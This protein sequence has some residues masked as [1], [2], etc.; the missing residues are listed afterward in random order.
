MH[1][2]WVRYALL[3]AVVA[4]AGAWGLSQRP[5]HEERDVAQER[6][7]EATPPLSPAYSI[8][9]TFRC[10]HDGLKAVELLVALYNPEA[11]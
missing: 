7:E 2:G 5:T 6:L 3:L 9:Q 1:G 8:G 4:V 10:H 11:K